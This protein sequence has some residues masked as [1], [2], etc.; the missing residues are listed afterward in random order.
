MLLRRS[1]AVAF[2]LGIWADVVDDVAGF[3]QFSDR[4]ADRIDAMSSDR[5][6][7]DSIFR[8]RAV[9]AHGDPVKSAEALVR[10]PRNGERH[11]LDSTEFPNRGWMRT[12][13]H[14]H[15]RFEFTV[16]AAIFS[17][18]VGADLAVIYLFRNGICLGR[19][20]LDDLSCRKEEIC[21]VDASSCRTIELQL[22]D[23]RPLAGAA[24]R[25]NLADPRFDFS[26]VFGFLANRMTAPPDTFIQDLRSTTDEHGRFSAIF[27]A[28]DRARVEHSAVGSLDNSLMPGR[29]GSIDHSGTVAIR[30]PPLADIAVRLIHPEGC[31]TSNLGLRIETIVPTDDGAF[32]VRAVREFP[33]GADATFRTKVPAGETTFRLLLN[34]RSRCMP[35]PTDPSLPR[36]YRLSPESGLDLEFKVTRADMLAARLV[37]DNGRPVADVEFETVTM[38]DRLSSELLVK[39]DIEGRFSIPFDGGD[40]RRLIDS[41]R[42]TRM[43]AIEGRCRLSLNGMSAAG[44]PIHSE[45]TIESSTRTTP[46]R[47]VRG[48]VTDD[49]GRPIPRA[50]AYLRTEYHEPLIR[51]ELSRVE[52]WTFTYTDADGRFELPAP[53][54]GRLIVG[55]DIDNRSIEVKEKFFRKFKFED[56]VDLR[57]P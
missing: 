38:S 44:V 36:T 22:H 37:D 5:A 57:L 43:R 52:T 49:S 50:R 11:N 17:T 35:E 9:D 10:F 45:R 16:P 42:P 29:A 30:L 13:T 23:R 48:R 33:I 31:D 41:L 54:E 6:S 26:D 56:P 21:V 8:G 53:L 46:G 55:A 47:R 24:V 28:D 14:G 20:S 7:T 19:F 27:T 1:L 34:S 18:A 12:V 2:L 3:S 40:I 4:R 25:A 32:E 51:K 39:S 15:G